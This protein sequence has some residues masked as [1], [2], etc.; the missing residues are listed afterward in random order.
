MY[1]FKQPV[2]W[3][4]ICTKCILPFYLI[5]IEY[6]AIKSKCEKCCNT[7]L[8]TIPLGEFDYDESKAATVVL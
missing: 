3:D 7:K 8:N 6:N 5:S 1:N 4:A 2:P